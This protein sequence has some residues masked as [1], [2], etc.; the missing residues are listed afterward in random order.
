M[1]TAVTPL[2]VLCSRVRESVNHGDYETCY[3]WI[4][5]AMSDYPDAPH[6]HNLMGILLEKQGNHPGAMKHFRAAW[7]LDPTYT[8]AEQNLK[9]YATFY[10]S[11]R[12]AF[13]ESDFEEEKSQPCTVQY[14]AHGVGHIFR[15]FSK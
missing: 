3:Q 9:N 1:Q 12:C 15:R 13:D 11:G 2:D 8:P 5:E 10:S 4:R 14:D 7:A 6:P